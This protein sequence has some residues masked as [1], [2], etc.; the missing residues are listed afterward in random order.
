ML[1]K[2]EMKDGYNISVYYIKFAKTYSR[3]KRSPLQP[4]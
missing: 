3:A 2:N 4:F 1:F